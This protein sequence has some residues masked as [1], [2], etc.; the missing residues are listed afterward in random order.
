M[1]L[2]KNFLKTLPI[3]RAYPEALQ[4]LSLVISALTL[5]KH[6]AFFRGNI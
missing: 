4:L 5:D 6:M 1:A 3:I 2:R